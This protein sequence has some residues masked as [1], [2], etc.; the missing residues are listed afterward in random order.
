MK[1]VVDRKRVS[2]SLKLEIEGTLSVV[3]AYASQVQ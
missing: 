2:E 3:G 1:S